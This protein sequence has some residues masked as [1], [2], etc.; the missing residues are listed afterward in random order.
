MHDDE[1]VEKLIPGFSAG[2]DEPDGIFG[3][4]Y[5]RSWGMVQ[6]ILNYCT[7][8]KVTNYGL[9]QIRHEYES[10]KAGLLKHFPPNGRLVAKVAEN[11]YDFNLR[12]V[13]NEKVLPYYSREAQ[14]YWE[15]RSTKFEHPPYTDKNKGV[16]DLWFSSYVPP[17]PF[18][19]VV[20][21]MLHTLEP[22]ELAEGR[23]GGERYCNGQEFPVGTKLARWVRMQVAK[24]IDADPNDKLFNRAMEIF[25]AAWSQITFT[26]STSVDY[27]VLSVNPLDILLA[28]EST[29]GW[30]SCHALS[31]D[32]RAG[33]LSYLTCG[34]TAIQYAYRT[35]GTYD[36]GVGL[37]LPRKMWRQWVYMQEDGALQMRQYPNECPQFAKTARGLIAGVLGKM[38]GVNDC[39]T[40]V[41][42]SGF[43]GIN[44]NERY[45]SFAFIDNPDDY[46]VRLVQLRKDGQNLMPQEVDFD[47]DIG[48]TV[49]CPNCGNRRDYD[50]ENDVSENG[51]G[52]LL[53][54]D[55]GES[56][57][58]YEC[59]VYISEDDSVSS[60][61]GNTYC[62][63]CYSSNFA[64]CYECSAECRVDDCY[65]LDRKPYCPDC[66]EECVTHCEECGDC[67]RCDDACSATDN[68][69]DE[70]TLCESCYTNRSSD[71]YECG[72]RYMENVLTKHGRKNLCKDCLQAALGEEAEDHENRE[73]RKN[74]AYKSLTW[75]A[76]S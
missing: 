57:R 14:A 9:N 76:V 18:S 71:C 4:D 35:W 23:L 31:G 50:D 30:H 51:V 19:A 12:D 40:V 73:N 58:C 59:G 63:S 36:C 52:S 6:K 41:R 27:V 16:F 26:R 60:D 75:E 64:S 1:T 28:S 68:H 74:D 38:H 29:T 67:V 47:N 8:N 10:K 13:W 7:E 49:Y 61:S 65:E 3:F 33:Q 43:V 45:H 54:S 11:S 34:Y 15:M 20:F 53:C 2:T 21:K 70:V 55:C 42:Q 69:G 44:H 32:Y 56:V 5:E 37:T 17:C 24:Y 39:I 72:K 25:L 22:R 62:Q 46:P 66:F 48:G